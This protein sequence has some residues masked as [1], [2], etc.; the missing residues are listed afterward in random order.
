MVVKG[1]ENPFENPEISL[2]TFRDEIKSC[3]RRDCTLSGRIKFRR[4]FTRNFFRPRRPSSSIRILAGPMG[5]TENTIHQTGANNKQPVQVGSLQGSSSFS[6]VCE[7]QSC[8]R[9]FF[10]GIEGSIKRK[11]R[12]LRNNFPDWTS[13]ALLAAQKTRGLID[14]DE[15]EF[16]RQTSF[17]GFG[18]CQPWDFSS[19]ATM[20][21]LHEP[22]R[23]TGRHLNNCKLA[24]TLDGFPGI[25]EVRSD[26]TYGLLR[27]INSPRLLHG[28]EIAV[29]ERPVEIRFGETTSS[30]SVAFA[31][32]FSPRASPFDRN[33]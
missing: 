12:R 24:K 17:A 30:P 16:P 14:V 31:R 6:V 26:A 4:R 20:P 29:N 9:F 13:S 28:C 32:G 8:R 27:V 2:R 3:V 22:G 21:P 18:V 15:G 5:K 25:L 11:D 23:L 10:P 7:H 19:T 33:L 1:C